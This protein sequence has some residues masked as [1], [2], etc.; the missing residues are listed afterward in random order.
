MEL[1]LVRHALPERQQVASGT[2]DPPLSPVGVEQ[3]AKVA[4]W[5]TSETIDTVFSSPMRRAKETAQA[6]A[7]LSTRSS[8]TKALSSS[9]A[10]R[11]AT[12]RWRS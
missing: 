5:L 11:R 8:S 6:Y 9:T 7:A 3:A 2:A 12:S 1:I 4:R 10:T